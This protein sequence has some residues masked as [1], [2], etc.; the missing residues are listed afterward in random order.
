MGVV[1]VVVVVVVLVDMIND[2]L[3]GFLTD[4][5]SGGHTGTLGQVSIKRTFGVSGA[6]FLETCPS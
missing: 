2:L 1:V 5:F 4:L 6:V 3:F